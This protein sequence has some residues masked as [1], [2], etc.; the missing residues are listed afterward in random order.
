MSDGPQIAGWVYCVSHPAWRNIGGAD[1][2]GVVKI[3][4]T[5]RDPARRL[6]E[7]T[8]RSALIQPGRVEFCLYVADRRRV[9]NRIKQ[10]TLRHKRLSRRREL[11]RVTPDEARAAIERAVAGIAS[12]PWRV[13]RPARARARRGAW[14]AP[15]RPWR[16]CSVFRWYRRE[17]RAVA[18]VVFV[19]AV[20]GMLGGW[21]H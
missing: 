14:Q 19:L 6:A 18:L 15:R 13:D 20:L 17:A 7:I 21:M 10:D 1:G 8:G 3:G 11:Y 4:S 5:S 16:R 2:P 9:E 12:T